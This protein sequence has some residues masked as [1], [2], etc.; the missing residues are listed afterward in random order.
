[1][2]LSIGV[3]QGGLNPIDPLRPQGIIDARKRRKGK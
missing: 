2:Q 1:M 3:L